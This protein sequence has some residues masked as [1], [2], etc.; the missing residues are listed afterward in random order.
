MLFL[1]TLEKEKNAFDF[2]YHNGVIDNDISLDHS[3]YIM[4][5]QVCPFNL[6]Q[7]PANTSVCHGVFNENK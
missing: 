1:L 5:S 6:G 3:S 2:V 4:S 7:I